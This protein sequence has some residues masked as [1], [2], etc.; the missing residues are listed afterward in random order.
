MSAALPS[1]DAQSHL[2][3]R[4]R[5]QWTSYFSNSSENRKSESEFLN[6]CTS[7][8]STYHCFKCPLPDSFFLTWFAQS[9]LTLLNDL[10]YVQYLFF[11]AHEICSNAVTPSRSMRPIHPQCLL[12][13]SPATVI[14]IRQV[15]I[16]IICVGAVQSCSHVS[17]PQ[18]RNNL[19][20][21]VFTGCT[22]VPDASLV[23]ISVDV[24]TCTMNG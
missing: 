5:V 4:Q 3:E 10:S 12:I 14:R 15:E 1:L 20:L 11:W 22:C 17:G 8:T 13:S 6:G 9:S 7:V 19:M 18:S 23:Y 2:E 24:S 21:L 16:S